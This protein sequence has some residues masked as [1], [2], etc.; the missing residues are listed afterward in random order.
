MSTEQTK[1]LAHRLVK[2]FNSGDMAFI[3]DYFSP[4]FVGHRPDGDTTYKDFEQGAKEL[5]NAFPDMKYGLDDLIAEGD[6][7]MARSTMTGTHKGNFM[8][9]P[10]TGK[11][12][13][14]W[15]ITIRRVAGGKCVEGWDL[16]DSLTMMQQLG[17][18]PGQ[19]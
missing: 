19:K 13:T 6:K 12:V 7:F 18:M 5:I 11:K 9:I 8:G 4:E 15:W 17:V 3:S 10:A 16:L 14:I 2:L 1:E